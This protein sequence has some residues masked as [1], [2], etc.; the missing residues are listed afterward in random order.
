[1]I[2]TTLEVNKKDRF[3]TVSIIPTFFEEDGNQA[4]MTLA[5]YIGAN[6]FYSTPLVEAGFQDGVDKIKN[7]YQ[8]IGLKDAAQ[9]V[10]EVLLD[11]LTIWGSVESCKERIYKI[12]ENTKLKTIILG[13]DPGKNVTI[14]MSPDKKYRVTFDMKLHPQKLR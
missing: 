3:S 1:M 6:E 8:K 12:I 5:R 14:K 10:G 2:N 9:N 11:E 13:F 4:K 7:A